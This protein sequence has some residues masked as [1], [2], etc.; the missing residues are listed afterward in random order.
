MR[1]G[2]APTG[3][4]AA[5]AGPADDLRRHAAAL[6]RLA[7]RVAAVLTGVRSVDAGSSPLRARLADRMHVWQAALDADAEALGARAAL[8]DR[9]AA[10]WPSPARAPWPVAAC[11]GSSSSRVP[12]GSLEPAGS[13]VA[14]L[15]GTAVRF[16]PVLLGVLAARLRA[17]AA[18]AAALG[19][20]VASAVGEADRA[21]TRMGVSAEMC[22]AA[23]RG[24]RLVAV[25]AP[26]AAADLELRM[27]RLAAAPIA[28][29]RAGP[30]DPSERIGRTPGA[31]PA[32]TASLAVAA[33][34]LALFDSDSESG[35]DSAPDVPD[36]ERL[37]AIR[38]R[39]AALPAPARAGV[40]GLLRDGPLT[41]LAAM[42]ARLAGTA[43]P[44]AVLAAV[45]LAGLADDLLAGAPTDLLDELVRALPWLEPAAPLA[46]G[47]Q[48]SG[49][50]LGVDRSGDAIVRD[51]VDPA[52]VGQGAVADCYLAAALIGLAR[53]DPALLAERLRRNPNGTVTITFSPGSGAT[54]DVTVTATLPARQVTASVPLDGGGGRGEAVQ[55]IAMDGDNAAGQPELWPALYEK[56]YARLHGGYPAIAFGSAAAAL[57]TLTGLPVSRRA[58]RATSVVDLTALLGRGEVVVLTTR[59]RTRP[60]GLV[61]AHAY[62]VLAVDAAR[63]RVL[64]R[65]PWDPAPD[66]DNVR[67]YA[68]SQVVTD[69][70]AVVHGSTR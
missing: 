34:L 67:W 13:P 45:E 2:P 50:V 14:G 62:P 56:A 41:V 16:D 48:R 40:I 22:G 59:T 8:L 24:L 63:G 46:A 42:A 60:G 23:R 31:R 27:S 55:E 10:G 21:M 69:V 15:G 12:P 57:R 65:N 43:R 38:A 17:A 9:L 39:L 20:E 28:L 35:S 7:M 3:G 6:R 25:E 58:A 70:H 32:A 5:L 61:A 30:S 33:G 4:A 53:Q 52:D 51:G 11:A 26:D 49:P 54:A 36:V 1:E 47:G 64:L 68:W 66:E 19:R 18:R 29:R 37:R 44:G